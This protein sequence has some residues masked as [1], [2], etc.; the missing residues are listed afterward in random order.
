MRAAWK[1]VVVPRSELAASKKIS[2]ST[3][4]CGLERTTSSKSI[5]ASPPAKVNTTPVSG[6]PSKSAVTSP[7]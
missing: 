6:R 3:P 1:A 4:L 7:S 5:S 2:T